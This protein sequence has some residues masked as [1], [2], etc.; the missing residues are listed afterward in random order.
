[1]ELAVSQVKK[2][3]S[4][5]RPRE[6]PVHLW[7]NWLEPAVGVGVRTVR[8]CSCKGRKEQDGKGPLHTY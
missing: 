3:K 7:V 2:E 1:M 5:F 4:L 6:W 8:S